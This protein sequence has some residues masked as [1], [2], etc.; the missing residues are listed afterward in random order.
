MFKTKFRYNPETLSYDRITTTFKEVLV[1]ASIMFAASIVIAICYFAVYSY[2]FDTPAKRSMLNTLSAAR[3]DYQVLSQDL[4][5]IERILADIQKRDDD[6]YRT[7]LESEPIPA[8]IRQAGFGGV[9]RY[10]ALEGYEHSRLMI[11]VTRHVDKIIKQLVVQSMSYDELIFKTLNKEQMTA[12]R[13]AIQPI[14]TKH[15][16]SV[17]GFG[18]RRS[19]PVLGYARMHEGM[20]FSAKTGT[21]IH[22]TGDGTVVKAERTSGGYGNVVVISHGFGYETLYAHMH[23]ISALPGSEVKRGDII[24]TVGSTGLSSGPHVHYEVHKNGRPVN[25]INYFYHDLSPDEY[26]RM[27]EQSQQNEIFDIW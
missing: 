1:K 25:P 11:D 3:F 15:L 23:T 2:F 19:H 18:W 12:S 17:A 5:H 22:A 26:V 20:D 13:P 24:G 16:T 8:S 7:I 14:S 9:N 6:V 21:P 27:D 10:E 4:H